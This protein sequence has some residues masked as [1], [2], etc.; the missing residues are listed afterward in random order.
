MKNLNVLKFSSGVFIA[1]FVISA[2]DISHDFQDFGHMNAHIWVEMFMGLLSLMAFTVIWFSIR[3]QGK[4]LETVNEDL[5]QVQQELEETSHK[6][7][8]LAEEFS[9]MVLQQFEDWQLTETEKEVGLLLLKGLSTGEIAEIRETK[10]KTVRQQASNL[11]KK[12]GLA[13]RHELAAYFFED[14]LQP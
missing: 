1:L 2:V 8:R 12:A 14:L 6:V 9:K 7:Q 11:Y 4:T 13:G 5:T 3:Q 10:E